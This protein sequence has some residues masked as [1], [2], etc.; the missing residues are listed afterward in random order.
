METINLE[1]EAKEA[2]ASVIDLKDNMKKVVTAC[3]IHII[4]SLSVQ[5]AAFF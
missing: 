5:C 1:E 3:H 4:V 2:E